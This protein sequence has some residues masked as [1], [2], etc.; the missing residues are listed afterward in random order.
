MKNLKGLSSNYLFGNLCK[1]NLIMRFLILLLFL[2]LKGI[3]QLSFDTIKM[4]KSVEET[5]G[6]EILGNYLITH[7]DSGDKPKLYIINQEGEKIMEIELNQ[8]KNKDW[9]DIAADSENYYIADTG[10]NYGTRENL[11][12]Y[13][14]DKDFFL[15]GKISIRYQ[16]QT[17]FSRELKN[18][19]DA[20]ALAVVGDHLVLF[21]KNRK[22][23]KSEIYSFPKVAGDYVLTPKAALIVMH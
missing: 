22:T 18:K 11:K 8:L 4:S 5:S 17:T 7:N 23:L 9:E 12:I 1:K 16:S 19:Y 13:I 15:Q 6:L 2:P 21:S 3:T 10:N 20:E 14:L